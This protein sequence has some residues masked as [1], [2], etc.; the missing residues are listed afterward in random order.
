MIS[1]LGFLA[2][3]GAAVLCLT[4]TP[5]A[6]GSSVSMDGYCKAHYG[7][8]A[9][10]VMLDRNDAYSWR[11]SYNGDYYNISVQDACQEQY[12]G[13]WVAILGDRDDAYS[14]SCEAGD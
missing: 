13:N 14:W 10:A 6:A 2:L 9:R 8:S 7:S 11:C 1:K 12:D 3:A 5:A 4:A